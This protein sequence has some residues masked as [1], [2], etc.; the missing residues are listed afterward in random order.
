MSVRRPILIMAGGT[1]GHVFPALAVA[2]Q[3]RELGWP[4]EWLG[5]QAGLEARVVPPTGIPVHWIR[6]K[7]LR[8]KG[9]LRQL[10]APF[11][12]LWALIQAVVILLRVRPAAVL[13][14]GGFTTG[15]GGVMAWLLRRPLLIH[16]Q[17]SVA[18]LTNRLL[19]RLARPVLEAFPG[20]LPDAVH[21]GNPV[22]AD[23]AQLSFYSP[24]MTGRRPRLLVVGGSLGAAA[25]NETVPVAL[26]R[27]Q[28]A[29]RP[30]VWHQTGVKL[31]DAAREA[32]AA[33]SVDVRLDAFIEDMAQAYQ[34]ADLVLC[35]SGA[36]T[37]AELA[38]V[39]VAS[40]L[41]PYP[42]AVDDHQTGNAHY[43][44]DAGA[45]RLLP[46]SE[47]NAESL[48]EELAL[49]NQPEQLVDMATRAR[50][51]AMPD[52]AQQV[53]EHCIRATGWKEAA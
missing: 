12:L 50:E 14:M 41:V 31:I 33:V 10:L 38:A 9:K 36:L 35:R 13:G 22:R 34:W 19:A 25:L 28:Q 39:G 1:G 52:A 8:G 53:A 30:E 48:C 11:M 4:V 27:L 44:V 42:H 49:L 20:S 16:E 6:V 51:H 37:I 5:T 3:L 46:Q 45:A 23:I 26:S 32:Y 24:E 29:E 7:G 21:T 17:N 15:P 47:M 43:L 40:I 18:G 2:E